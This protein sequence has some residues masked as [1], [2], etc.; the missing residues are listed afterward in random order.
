LDRTDSQWIGK[1]DLN[2]YQQQTTNFG[3]NPSNDGFDPLNP[4]W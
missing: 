4:Q 3:G 2:G 1:E